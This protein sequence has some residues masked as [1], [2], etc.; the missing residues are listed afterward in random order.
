MTYGFKNGMRV[1]YKQEQFIKTGVV[2]NAPGLYWLN[3]SPIS[4]P[5]T[6]G[7]QMTRKGLLELKRQIERVLAGKVGGG[8]AYGARS[9]KVRLE[10]VR[11]K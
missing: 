2:H 10:R 4:G 6:Q 7:N 3:I 1:R 8:W 11:A 5:P 9:G